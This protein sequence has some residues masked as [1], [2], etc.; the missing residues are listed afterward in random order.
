[1]LGEKASA[2]LIS[3]SRDEKAAKENFAMYLLAVALFIQGQRD[4]KQ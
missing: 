4:T 2:S 3:S 1:M